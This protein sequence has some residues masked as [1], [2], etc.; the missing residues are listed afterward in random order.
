MQKSEAVNPEHVRGEMEKL[1][2]SKATGTSLGRTD[3]DGERL[4]HRRTASKQW[5]QNAFPNLTGVPR[6]PR[7]LTGEPMTEK[8]EEFHLKVPH[9]K[10]GR[11]V[12]LLRVLGSLIATRA[13]RKF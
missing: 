9:P 10:I 3:E 13:S 11:D 1:G 12:R 7:E 4:P 8:R 2:P 6:N 5:Q